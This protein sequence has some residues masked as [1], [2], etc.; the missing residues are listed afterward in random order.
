MTAAKLTAEWQGKYWA[1]PFYDHRDSQTTVL[2]LSR[3]HKPLTETCSSERQ[4]E[5]SVLIEYSRE[6]P[7]LLA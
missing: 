7:V 2:F 5:L 1:C 3:D 6:P 4:R